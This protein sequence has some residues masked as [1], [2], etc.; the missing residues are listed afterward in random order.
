MT[1]NPNGSFEV[2]WLLMIR[3][4]RFDLGHLPY[5]NRFQVCHSPPWLKKWFR[6]FFISK[7]LAVQ[8]LFCAGRFI[9]A[10]VGEIGFCLEHG[11]QQHQWH[12]WHHHS[13]NS[14]IKEIFR[15]RF[16]YWWL[17]DKKTEPY[18]KIFYVGPTLPK[19]WLSNLKVT[20]F[21]ARRLH[22]I[23]AKVLI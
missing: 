8:S 12:W 9:G 14:L 7:T 15:N 5:R 19:P 2:K 21:P 17:Q 1:F 23:P 13:L 6:E 4:M 10:W 20:L 11:V 22:K 18:P 16:R 3:T